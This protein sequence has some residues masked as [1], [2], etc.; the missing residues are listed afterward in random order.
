[1]DFN[2][3]DFNDT[4]D[5]FKTNY[6]LTNGD[7]HDHVDFFSFAEASTDFTSVLSGSNPEYIMSPLQI[8]HGNT[9]LNPR[10]Y[11]LD[12]LAGE[13]EEFLSPLESPA[14]A[15]TTNRHTET[16]SPLTSPALHAVP[17][18]ITPESVLQ[19]KLALIERQQHQLRTVHRQ[20][21]SQEFLA[22]ATPSLLMKLGR[23]EGRPMG[24]SSSQVDNMAS[25]PAAMLED[26][27]AAAPQKKKQPA[28]KR[29]KITKGQAFTSPGLVPT[30]RADPTIAAL[31]SPAA[32]RPITPASPRALKP[33]IS[34]SLQPNG[35]RL[36]AIEE[37]VAAA[38]LATK[39]NYQNM[40]EGK[41][42]SLGIDF[43]S[44]FQSGVENRRSAH[45]AAE[46]KRRDTLKQSFDS[47]RK[48]I[49]DALVDEEE[50]RDN[51]EKEVKQMSKVVLIQHSYEYILRL[52]AE[53]RR[54]D[55]ALD[56]LREE[57]RSL[58]SQLAEKKV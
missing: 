56:K 21:E 54:K 34:P 11:P 38:A 27:A 32:L 6:E 50:D 42:K 36:S 20:L 58:Q 14:I 8:S 39:S 30:P 48:E 15:P 3:L 31:V 2:G 29:R 52:K 51:K 10:A 5:V 13:E 26:V 1:M 4:H 16:F 24:P 18:H 23:G 12:G 49:A 7:N 44:S 35:K 19:Q 57:V 17:P 28:S 46:Q 43:S 25:L 22:P 53:N 55:E 47:L 40:R 37:Q 45:K 41:A 33:L 9:S